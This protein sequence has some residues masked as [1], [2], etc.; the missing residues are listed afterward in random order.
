MH[1]QSFALKIQV[2]IDGFKL[3]TIFGCWWQ[4]IFN[5]LTLTS[6][7]QMM[8]P[9]SK[10]VTNAFRLQRP[11][12]TSIW[13]KYSHFDTFLIT[14]KNRRVGE[15]KD[16]NFFQ[17]AKSESSFKSFRDVFR[18]WFLMRNELIFSFSDWLARFW[19]SFKRVFWRQTCSPSA[20]IE[21]KERLC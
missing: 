17:Q 20:V 3:V 19:S 18:V 1:K 2:Y 12:P 10:V 7:I 9:I 8:S 13:P 16:L 11:S 5:L 4:K 14:D 15:T 6:N 21:E